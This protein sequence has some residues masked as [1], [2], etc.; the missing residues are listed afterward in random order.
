MKIDHNLLKK[1]QKLSMLEIDSKQEQET[2]SSLEDVV[3]F[4]DN[5][6]DLDL[7][8]IKEIHFNPAQGYSPLREDIS[9]KNPDISE[10][11]LKNAPSSEN[12]FFIVP[13]IIE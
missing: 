5:L 3:N 4:T 13:N 2:I 8:H 7:S 10:D 1:L 11:I 9:E 12:N 6:N